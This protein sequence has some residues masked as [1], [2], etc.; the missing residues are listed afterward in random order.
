MLCRHWS[1]Q[2]S[3]MSCFGKCRLEALTLLP[4]RLSSRARTGEDMVERSLHNQRMSLSEFPKLVVVQS[5]I[6]PQ[7]GLWV[8]T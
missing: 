7:L 2:P 4:V 8:R 5:D 6:F 3:N 1:R